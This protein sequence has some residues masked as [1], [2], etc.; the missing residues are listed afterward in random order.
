MDEL[1]HKILDLLRE[2]ARMSFSEIGNAVGISRVSVKKRMTA[3]EN[4]GIIR[5]YHAVTDEEQI[6]KGIRYT[7]DIEAIPEEYGEV[8]KALRK[9]RELEEIYSTTGN[10]RIHCIGRS[11]NT[12]TMES[13]VNYLFNHTKGIRKIGWHILL[14]DLKAGE[15]SGD[16][17]E[18]ESQ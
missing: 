10:C 13:H 14:S 12:S 1:D 8:V 9:D 3:M 15:G 16:G 5:G 2:N 7:I 11:V 18:K 17:T 6:R 4:A